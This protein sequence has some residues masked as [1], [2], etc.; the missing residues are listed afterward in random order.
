MSAPTAI[1]RNFRNYLPVCVGIETEI[2]IQGG[3]A[4]DKPCFMEVEQDY[5]SDGVIRTEK[6]KS[7]VQ[8][9]ETEHS[10]RLTWPEV[11]KFQVRFRGI[12]QDGYGYHEDFQ[13]VVHTKETFPGK[14]P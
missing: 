9:P 11:G 1:L 4:G 7:G 3:I 5:L 12:N 2:R 13:V 6:S 10:F 14:C 8:D